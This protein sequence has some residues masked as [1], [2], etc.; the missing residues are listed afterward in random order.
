MI[1]T[2]II[3]FTC[4]VSFCSRAD[5]GVESR[6]RKEYREHGKCE[7]GGETVGCRS[8]MVDV[9]EGARKDVK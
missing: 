7:T 1:L 8:I 9:D 4:F 2:W 6:R 5:R 3:F